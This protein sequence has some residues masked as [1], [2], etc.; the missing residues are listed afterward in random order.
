M[1]NEVT[2]AG[3]TGNL[4]AT[5]IL[6]REIYELLHDPTDI[7][8]T[9]LEIPYEAGSAVTRV[10]QY[11]PALAMSAPGEVTQSTNTA[12]TDTGYNLTLAH[13]VL[14]LEESYL[15]E[16]TSPDGGFDVQTLASICVK[17]ATLTLTDL[18]TALFTGLNTSVGTTTVD[19]VAD[20]IF[21]ATYALRDA[22]VPGP[23][24]CVLYPRQL[25]DFI[26][27]LRGE[28]GP[29]QYNPASQDIMRMRG[30]GF[31][32][33]WLDVQFWTSDSVVTANAGADSAGAIYGRGAFAFQEGPVQRLIPHVPE[34]ARVEGNKMFVA[35][36]NI[37]DYG[38]LRITGHYFPA[39]AEAE[40]G[41]GVKIVTDR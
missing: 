25:S 15:A 13:Y 20:D 7:R 12:V 41:R 11:Q 24:Y 14:Q 8:A 26:E 34:A 2:H 38:K 31:A 39:V 1:A 30:P 32:A 29:M 5:H 10:G 9:C 21:D 4:R 33:D 19:L 35:I 36:S 40:D 37:E 17:S 16:V 28:T 6:H 23:Y 22:L 3:I 18:I 27:S